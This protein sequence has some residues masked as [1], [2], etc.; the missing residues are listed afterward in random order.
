MPKRRRIGIISVPTGDLNYGY[1]R[2]G[3]SDILWRK[4]SGEVFVSVQPE[5]ILLE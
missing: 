2:V 5:Q 1:L 4:R 3:F